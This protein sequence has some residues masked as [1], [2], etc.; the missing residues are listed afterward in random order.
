MK[1]YFDEWA[2]FDEWGPEKRSRFLRWGFLEGLGRYLSPQSMTGYLWHDKP[3]CQWEMKPDCCQMI[4][5]KVL[6]T[7]LAQWEY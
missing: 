6:L 4:P 2:R 5:E 3:Q 7:V 1:M